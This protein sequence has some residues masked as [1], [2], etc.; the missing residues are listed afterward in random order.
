MKEWGGSGPSANRLR[1]D[2]GGIPVGEQQNIGRHTRFEVS[3]TDHTK[4]NS[5]QTPIL[6]FAASCWI[7]GLAYQADAVRGTDKLSPFDAA[8]CVVTA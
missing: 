5:G 1:I 4:I 8:L 3:T 7:A 2:R 6:R